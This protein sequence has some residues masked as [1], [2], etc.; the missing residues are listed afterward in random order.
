MATGPDDLT[1]W[2]PD[3]G[4]EEE[5]ERV[6]A[7]GK[8][9]VESIEAVFSLGETCA[10][11]MEAWDAAAANGLT[12]EQWRELPGPRRAM[13]VQRRRAGRRARQTRRNAR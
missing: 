5:A 10:R 3:D 8:R 12:M 2:R 11:F 6:A 7:D 9:F 1:S 13:L 4:S